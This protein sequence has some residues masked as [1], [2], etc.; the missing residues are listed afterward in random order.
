M[1]RNITKQLNKISASKKASIAYII[2]GI[3]SRSINIVTMPMFTR[4][5]SLNEMGIVNTFTSWQTVLYA[6][7][8]LSLGSGAVSAAMVYYKNQRDEYLS[9]TLG[10]SSV[11]AII[12]STILWIFRDSWESLT[13]L[14]KEL[15]PVFMMY[16]LLQPALDFWYAKN[17]FE[18]KYLPVVF[19]SSGIVIFSGLI[20][21]CVVYF[22]RNDNTADLSIIRIYSQYSV[23]FV[24]A[25][26]IFLSIIIKGKK[27]FNKKI[28][29]WSFNL[30]WPL[31]IHSLA[32]NLLD[33]SDRIM[34]AKING[35]AEAALCGTVHTICNM[36]LILWTAI[37]SALIP[38]TFLKLEKDP[39]SISDRMY[40]I[41]K[42]FGL[43]TILAVLASPEILKILTSP[44]Y[45]EAVY[46][47]P[48]LLVS[49]FL[50]SLYSIYG[51]CLL[52]KKKTKRIMCGTLLA[53]GCNIGLN[54][55]LLPVV[56]YYAAAY[57][58]LI[59]SVILCIA[60]GIMCRQV[61]RINV[62]DTRKFITLASVVVICSLVISILFEFLI[63]RILLFVCMLIVTIKWAMT[64]LVRKE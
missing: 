43:V 26:V 61:Y 41:V 8:S 14:P 44:S 23:I 60:Q 18:N 24:I 37:N 32:K 30:S 7:V 49:V 38:Y 19:V 45:Y 50:N 21:L 15:L 12:F 13:T 58:T 62:L 16:F 2:A 59:S 54:A 27:L 9:I 55:I 64:I 34:V 56:G 10:L 20:S 47:M 52:F 25:C 4:L 36:M 39:N 5:L 63:I 22:M 46:T 33:A 48:P 35:S 29:I 42:L 28:W 31:I 57:T 1:I 17:K 51:N 3:L 53:T 11:S 40:E 6:I